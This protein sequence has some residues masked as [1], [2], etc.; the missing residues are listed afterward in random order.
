[1][2]LDAILDTILDSIKLLPFLF[3]TYL[4]MEFLEHKASEK[5]EEIVRRSGKWGPLMGSLL[6]VVPQ[7]GFSTAGANLYAGRIISRGTLIAI[8]LSTSDE[9]LPILISEKMKASVIITIIVIKILIGMA[10]GFAI[11]IIRERHIRIKSK[12]QVAEDIH[13]L[14][15]NEHCKCDDGNFFLSAVSHTIQVFVFIL[16][17]SLV[18]NI[19]I[20]VI[21]EEHIAILISNN[22]VLS[23]FLS[24]IVGLIPN[25]AASVVISE[26]FAEGFLS[27]GAM[28]AGL[29]T[30]SGVGLLVLFKVNDDIKENLKIL[31]IL[32]GIG[33]VVGLLLLLIM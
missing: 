9:M 32:Y 14:C 8:F 31:G 17:I 16:I 20:G 19:A 6:G 33:V 7:C 23:V 22:G 5:T 21:G 11:D 29:L 28:M 24:A 3:I 10:V 15:D 18:L 30:G 13:H 1:M 12:G 2:I 26:M 27:F 4:A 25:C